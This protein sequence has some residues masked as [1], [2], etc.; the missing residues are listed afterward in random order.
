[1]SDKKGLDKKIE[2]A[3]ARTQRSQHQFRFMVKG[4]EWLVGITLV[5]HPCEIVDVFNVDRES[6][7]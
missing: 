1:M 3:A 5:I 4:P 2:K 7:I 6:S